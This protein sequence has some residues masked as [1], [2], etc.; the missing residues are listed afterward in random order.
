[1]ENRRKRSAHFSF[2]IFIFNLVYVGQLVDCFIA[3]VGWLFAWLDG[4]F[5]DEE[6]SGSIGRS[7]II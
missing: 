6:A 2:F 3:L 4:W 1:M 7:K 5:S